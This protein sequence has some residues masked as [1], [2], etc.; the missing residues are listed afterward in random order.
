MSRLGIAVY[1][2]FIL[3]F[4]VFCYFA[5]RFAYFPGDLSI[6]LW[7]QGIDFSGLKPI[8][9]FAPYAIILA[10]LIGLKLWLPS[11]RRAVVFIALT[12]LAAGLIT[13][14]IKL[15]VNRPRPDI[16][17]VQIAQVI[18]GSDFPSGHTACVTVIGGFLFYLAPRLVKT[19][20]ARGL[21]RA[22]LI[23]IILAVGVSRI[24]LGAHWA[25]GVVGGLFLGGLLLYPAIVLYNKYDAKRGA[26][27]A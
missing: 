18:L 15:L 23:V 27:H 17:L 12:A 7:I 11:R 6:S 8:M 1:A 22:L 10:V 20:A 14:L 26:K 5:H 19:P 2:F 13:W 16:E 24:Y 9:Q 25:S 4:G 21:L 3:L